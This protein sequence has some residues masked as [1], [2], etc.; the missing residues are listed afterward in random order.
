LENNLVGVKVEDA[1]DAMDY[2]FTSSLGCYSKLMQGEMCYKGMVKL[3]AQKMTC[4]SIQH[5]P[6]NNGMNSI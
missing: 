1:H 2:S 3:K 6:H 4:E 5:F